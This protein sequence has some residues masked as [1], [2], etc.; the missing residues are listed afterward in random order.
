MFAEQN[1]D[2]TLLW[3]VGPKQ[4]RIAHNNGIYSWKDPKCT[5][6][7]LGMSGNFRPKVL[8]RIL[9]ANHSET[10]TIIPKNIE[11]NMYDWATPEMEIFVDFETTCSV[12]SEQDSLPIQNGASLIFL[13]GAGY[14]DPKTKKWVYLKFLADNLTLNEETRICREF[15]NWVK[16]LQGK[17]Q[18]K[19]WH[20]SHAEPSF[21]NR[22][23]RRQPQK[24]RR[25]N[26]RLANQL[27]L[28]EIQND[29][30]WCDLLK[31]F[32]REPIGVKGCLNYSLKTIAKTFY[33]HG[34]IKTVWDSTSSTADGADVAVEAYRADL[35]CKKTGT[36]FSEHPLAED[37]VRYNEVDCKVLQEILDYLR[38]N[39]PPLEKRSDED[40][41]YF[42]DE[43]D[44]LSLYSE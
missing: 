9:E 18:V 8:S 16:K 30:K 24:K 6:E 21:W 32:L 35:E 39:H 44:D 20:W 10:N 23:Y 41:F 15:S 14:I 31:I 33:Q 11:N 7:A 1:D 37:I 26:R 19:L 22:A 27:G 36:R 5:S 34:F 25:I 13:I 3:Y 17:N 40:D 29:F 4:R 2:L 28:S 38:T 42:E 12:F 43:D